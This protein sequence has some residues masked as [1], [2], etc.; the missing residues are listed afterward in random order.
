M[1]RSLP[2][3]LAGVAFLG[4]LV[5]SPLGPKSALAVSGPTARWAFD[6]G[7]GTTVADSVGT[8]NG[9]KSGGTS[10]LTT[11]AA[12]GA[13]AMHFD[14][15][16]GRVDVPS[17]ASLEPAQLT[18]T[19]WVRGSAASPPTD[20][21]VIVE[22]GAF[23][24]NGPS[25]GLSVSTDGIRF[26]I[27]TPDGVQRSG[28]ATAASARTTLW[29]G[30]WHLVSATASIVGGTN[31]TAYASID[32]VSTLVVNWWIGAP[33]A[34]ALYSG[35][36][37]DALSIGSRSNVACSGTNFK[38]D[39]DDVRVYSDPTVDPGSLMPPVTV[40]VTGA[41]PT[42]AHS[43]EVIAYSAHWS[44]I[45]RFGTVRFQQLYNGQWETIADADTFGQNGDVSVLYP[46]PYP[47][48]TIPMRAI[49]V[50]PEPWVAGPEDDFS[51]VVTA[52][53]STTTLAISPSPSVPFQDETLTA[54]VTST[55]PAFGGWPAGS[56]EFYDTTGVSPILVGT[57]GVTQGPFGTS[58]A[59]LHVGTLD[60]GTHKFKAKYIG[61][62]EFRAGSQSADTSVIIGKAET[63]IDAFP[64]GGATFEA[65]HSFQLQAQVNSPL[66]GWADSATITFRRVGVSTPICTVNADPSNQ[67]QCT[68][69]AQPL[70]GWQYT[71]TYSG[72]SRNVGSTSAP[73]DVTI[74]A[75]LVHATGVGISATSV[76]PVVD[77][78]R[79]TVAIRG[80][81]GEPINVAI[82]IYNATNTLVKYTTFAT[83]SGAY[84]YSWNGRN[85]SGTILAE[86]TYRIVQTLKDVA[87]TSMIV[88]SYVT[89]SKKFIHWHTTTVA[90]L[91][92]SFSAS[93][94]AGSGTVSYNT[95]SGYVR[96]YAPHGDYTDWAGAGWQLTLPSATLYKY[97]YFKVYAKHVFQTG[98]PT[99]IGSQNFSTCAYST[100]W[101]E[102]C[103]DAWKTIGNT[104]TT[105]TY[106]TSS[107]TSAHRYG[108]YVRGMVSD[109]GGTT[110]VYKAEATVTYGILSY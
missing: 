40:T 16:D 15:V 30:A 73:T 102:G 54:T 69:P 100:T 110:Y 2:V 29:D 44:P 34:V 66:S 35:E 77:T 81:R 68:V 74:V 58:T 79:D 80:T 87:G 56:V 94:H 89:L 14:G 93:G 46:A 65:D 32:N 12:V 42:T 96:L 1:R 78:Y 86:G 83:G 59:V 51:M 104:G 6:A 76:Y 105:V 61:P 95:T 101:D 4:V 20:G 108:R 52:W 18:L 38:G 7:T 97:L 37:T 70:G 48:S 57:V 64:V 43:G 33:T 8:A 109:Y 24:C 5:P 10:W 53:P 106:S 72:N 31:V 92:S 36:T 90:K 3:A 50:G 75:D 27:R 39:I 60:I 17:G 22:K 26:S 98:A 71:A 9:T 99:Q 13:G 88:T 11:G 21:Q 91:G 67:T 63:T 25:Y 19:A 45:P 84:S 41:G 82:R 55:V 62:D 23:G 107:L 47:I 85:T 103:F 28:V 49:Y